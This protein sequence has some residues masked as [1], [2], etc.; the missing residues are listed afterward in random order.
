MSENAT[1]NPIHMGIADYVTLGIMLL[2]SL[3]IGV[4]FAIRGGKNETKVPINLHSFTERLLPTTISLVNA[5]Y[6]VGS[7][8]MGALP[9]CLS[10]FAT[11]QSAISLLGV[12]AEVYTYGTMNLYS[13]VAI[14]LSY[15]IGIV[16]I[17]PLMHP[18]KVTSVNEYL[19]MRFQS[20]TVRLVGT[21][22]GVISS[23]S[24]MTVAL[25]SPALALQTAV[26]LPLW[27]SIVLVGAVGTA[28]TAIGGIKSVVW[29]DVFQ[30]VIIFGGIVVIL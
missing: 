15:L 19:Q 1:V 12:P 20:R 29:T 17:I 22:I 7:R 26:D 11:F 3:G 8:R 30:T 27:M 25:L 10:L 2:I 24:Y 23:I 4:F 16:T 14:V 18:L 28:Y 5:E 13:T 21:L 9:V 6:L